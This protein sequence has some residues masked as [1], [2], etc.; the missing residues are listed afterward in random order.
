MDKING[1][2]LKDVWF[3]SWVKR[4]RALWSLLMSIFNDMK[5]HHGNLLP[6]SHLFCYLLLLRVVC[7]S[8]S[9]KGPHGT[10]RW[11]S[12]AACFLVK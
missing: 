11:E 1:Y 4:G 5:Q 2:N 8:E 10:A 6:K 7:G 9:K 12:H 3:T